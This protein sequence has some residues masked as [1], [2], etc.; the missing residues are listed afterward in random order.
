MPYTVGQCGD[1]EWCV[2]KDDGEVVGR[3][4]SRDAANDQ[5]TALDI[6]VTSQEAESYTPPQG[7]RDAAQ[8]ALDWRDEYGR[9]GTDVGIAR[10]RDL[11]NG[12]NISADTIQRMVS[13]FA[14][15]GANRDKHYAL[16]DGVPTTFRI[17]WDLWGGDDGRRWSNEI[18]RQ[19]KMDK[20]KESATE[21][22]EDAPNYRAT[23]DGLE[24]CGNC[25][26]RRGSICT[27]F[28]FE[29]SDEMTCDDHQFAEAEE[30]AVS[31][32]NAIQEAGRKLNKRNMQRVMDAMK[33]LQEMI[34]EMG[35]YDDKEEGEIEEA[36][37]VAETKLR[38]QERNGRALIRII[39][40]G[41][42]SSGY[43][44]A[45]VL[46]RDGPTVF[47]AGTKLYLNHPTK[48][49]EAERPERDIRDLAGKLASDAVWFDDGLYADVEYY[50]NHRPLIAA[51]GEDL[52]V[53]I[54]ADGTYRTGEAEGRKGRIIE[55][56]VRA[57]SIDFVTRAGAGGK[58]A[59]LMEAHTN[60]GTNVMRLM[61]GRQDKPIEK[62]RR[63]KVKPEELTALQERLARLEETNQAHVNVRTELEEALK[64]ERQ[65]RLLTEAR[66]YI[67]ER[68]DSKL[69]Q[70][71]VARLSRELERNIP[72]TED[73]MAIDYTEFSKHIKEASDVAWVELAEAAPSGLIRGMGSSAPA[74]LTDAD[75]DAKIEEAFRASGMDEQRAKIAA[76][77]VR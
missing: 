21:A 48:T 61:E 33:M 72:Y 67:Q 16:E 17:A 40:P 63:G 68:L 53:S 4:D 30:A 10:A 32:E 23:F 77:G 5:K 19:R 8:R 41:W 28:D 54:R 58:V 29:T 14:R 74:V 38:E 57:E 6:N 49:E 18:A 1:D 2:V 46:R 24:T 50:N 70:R 56:L 3:H 34:D 11:A 27:R 65:A 62:V 45:E 66:H 71:T 31:L 36:S 15:H 73:G 9:G 64:Q 55:Q 47:T 39:T 43:Y 51:I 25:E 7:V 20:K 75:L 59:R 42:G 37:F 76:R 22:Q 13:F 52:D 26:F 69:P 60:D 44:P 35:D 12:R